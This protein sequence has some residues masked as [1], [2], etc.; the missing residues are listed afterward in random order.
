MKPKQPYMIESRL[1]STCIIVW[2][3]IDIGIHYAVHIIE[4]MRIAGNLIGIVAAL[5]A[6]LGAARSMVPA[7]LG[8]AVLGVVAVNSAH[9]LFWGAEVPVAIFI[10]VSLVMLLRLAQIS[11]L[12]AVSRANPPR[13][14]SRRAW[15]LQRWSTLPAT[16]LGLAV[17]FGAGSQW[18]SPGHAYASVEQT[19]TT[20]DAAKGNPEEGQRPEILSAF[21]GLDNGLP[22]R[23]ENLVRGATGMDG[24]PVIFSR[25]IDLSTL[26]AGD[27]R[28]T[29]ASGVTGFVHGVT[30]APAAGEG[31]LRTVLLVGEFGNEGEDPPVRV[32]IVGNIHTIDGRQNFLGAQ[33]EVIPLA[34]GP[35]IIFAEVVPPEQWHIGRRGNLRPFAGSGAPADGFKQAVRVVW[36][37]GVKLENGK[38]P[39]DN[40]RSLYKITVAAP[41]GSMRDVSPMAIADLHDSDNNHLLFLDTEDRPVSVSFPAGILID[42]NHDLNPETVVPV[43]HAERPTPHVIPPR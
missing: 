24:M 15:W 1:L 30:L 39:G 14:R 43:S 21:F 16:G 11:H 32:E 18:D 6:L 23:A 42:P 9:P 40:E 28:V 26:Q 10:G 8:I 25:E 34:D 7:M 3:L 22:R 38:E 12:V 5:L 20:P 13:D 41:D 17:I 27:F 31:E 4:P 33:V 36:A 19:D 2:N 29:Q 35:T 37:G